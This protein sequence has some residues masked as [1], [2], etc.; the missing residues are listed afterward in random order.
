[1]FKSMLKT[2]IFPS[3]N[4]A[5][6][7]YPELQCAFRGKLSKWVL[8]YSPAYAKKVMARPP[9]MDLEDFR[10]VCDEMAYSAIVQHKKNG[11]EPSDD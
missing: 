4:I 8:W 11:V 7:N 1:M 2:S 10:N 9:T 6:E 3:H 5:F